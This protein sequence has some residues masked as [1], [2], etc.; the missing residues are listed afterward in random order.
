MGPQLPI[1][2]MPRF[3]SQTLALYESVT[4]L[5]TYDSRIVCKIACINLHCIK[6]LLH[7]IIDYDSW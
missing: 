1:P 6:E 5:L 4:Y 7:L 3:S 2:N